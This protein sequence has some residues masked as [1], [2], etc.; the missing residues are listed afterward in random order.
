M[1]LEENLW[2]KPKHVMQWRICDA[3]TANTNT[4]RRNEAAT[5]FLLPQLRRRCR[6]SQE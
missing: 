1:A 3:E 6:H 2:T 4:I 5:C